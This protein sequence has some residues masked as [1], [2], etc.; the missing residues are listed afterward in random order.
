M[1][2]LAHLYLSGEADEILLGN[3]IGDYVKGQ[4]YRHFS[5]D[6]R[7][8]I[9]LHRSI[10]SFTDTHPVVKEAAAYFRPAYGRY[11]G[12]VTDV[13][14]DHFLARY[15]RQYSPHTLRQFAKHVHAVLLANFFQLP[16]RVQGFLP[17]LIQHKRL[18]S[19]ARLDGIQQS[20]HIMAR[21]TSLPDQTSQ[22]MEV[23]ERNFD[24]LRELFE[25][26]FEDLIDHVESSSGIQIER[27][28]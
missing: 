25:R 3:F 9:L 17:F 18:E 24:E 8:G 22:A 20:L 11:C 10:D 21:R 13:I 1:N 15:W 23:L 6:V 28:K 12:I 2:Y 4:Q 5:N 7:K 27:L 14:F 26:F 16:V 19:Y